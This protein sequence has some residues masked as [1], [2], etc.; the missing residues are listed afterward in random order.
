MKRV[1][2]ILLVVACLFG[3]SSALGALTPEPAV[4]DGPAYPRP[5]VPPM[6]PPSQNNIIIL[7]DGPA[8]P[9]PIVP[10]M[11]PPGANNI[12]IIG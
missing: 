2:T 10:P 8:Y 4:A 7:G 5:I 1:L 3:L 12:V 6:E 9:R 11:E